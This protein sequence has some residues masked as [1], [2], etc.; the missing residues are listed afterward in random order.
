MYVG[1]SAVVF[2]SGT[3]PTYSSLRTLHAIL[4]EIP[5][6]RRHALERQVH[7]VRPRRRVMAYLGVLRRLLPAADRLD[8]VAHVHDIRVAP[9]F[10]PA[11]AVGLHLLGPG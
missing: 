10:G 6:D 1:G 3:R 2:M 8:E 9:P 4:R 11:L 7:H 5:L